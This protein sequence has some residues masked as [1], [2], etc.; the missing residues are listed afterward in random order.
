M[1]LAE[2]LR[3]FL[4]EEKLSLL[5]WSVLGQAAS[6]MPSLVAAAAGELQR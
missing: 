2:Q 5:S 6:S 4:C 3:I 1:L